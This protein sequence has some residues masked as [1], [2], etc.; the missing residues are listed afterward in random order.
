MSRPAS[1]SGNAYGF[2]LR[3]R[4]DQESL[5]ARLLLP[6]IDE[7]LEHLALLRAEV[8]AQYAPKVELA[9]QRTQSKDY[10]ELSIANYP[11]GFCSEI[12]NE[13]LA[14]MLTS[15]YF[16]AL[17]KRG[18]ALH[19]VFIFLRGI[20]FQNAIQL[21]N[22]YIDA[23]N[24]T[25]HLEKP[26]LDWAPIRKL[27]YENLNSWS[28]FA[29]VATEYLKVQL[30]PNFYFPL[31]FAAAPFLAINS[32]GNLSLLLAQNIIFH[33]DIAEGMPRILSLLEDSTW[34]SR[35]LPEPYAALL[36][37][38]CASN[39]FETFPLEYS[40]CDPQHLRS[41]IIP[42]FI[43]L[44]RQPHAQALATLKAYDGMIEKAAQALHASK[45]RP[46]TQEVERLRMEGL[47]PPHTLAPS[48]ITPSYPPSEENPSAPFTDLDS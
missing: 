28:R 22:L 48:M 8:D 30:Y 45:L 27:D 47:I 38:H 46:S 6:A 15:P 14:R 1:F 36:K 11:F 35:Q 44:A 29:T 3:H 42:E 17:Q 21:G 18:V 9:R 32:S 5:T 19:S 33:K 13:V 31:A 43:A 41:T 16:S 7:I 20:Y 39:I 2:D 24:D 4:T 10:S 23:A 25:A 12:R 34:M 26:K 37:N 40:P